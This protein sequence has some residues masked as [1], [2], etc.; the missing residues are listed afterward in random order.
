MN[1]LKIA[2]IK[3]ILKLLEDPEPKVF[4]LLEPQLLSQDEQFYS[5]LKNE[6]SNSSSDLVKSRLEKVFSK[7]YYKNIEQ[8]FREIPLLENGELDLEEG[9]FLLATFAYPE[10][11][12]E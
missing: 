1:K 7:I 12:I 4:E 2:D 9:T 10:L 6:M 3:N 8:L 11:K 5:V